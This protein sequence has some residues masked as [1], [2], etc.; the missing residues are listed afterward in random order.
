[1]HFPISI[2]QLIRCLL[3]PFGVT[4]KSAYVEIDEDLLRV[5]FGRLFSENIPLSEIVEVKQTEHP[6][7]GGLGVQY[8]KGQII[9]VT[10]SYRGMVAIQFRRTLDMHTFMVFACKELRISLENPSDFIQVLQ[11]RIGP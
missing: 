8:V 4:S 6:W 3:F 7:W 1:M 2:N 5:R 11:E 10:G 9:T